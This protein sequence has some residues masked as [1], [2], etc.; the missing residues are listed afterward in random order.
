MGCG[1]GGNTNTTTIPDIVVA[2]REIYTGDCDITLDILKKWQSILK[3]IKQTNTY[4]KI[5]VNEFN[6]NQ[7]LGL[8]QSAINYPDNYCY[9]KNQLDYFKDNLLVKILE[10]VP[11]CIDAA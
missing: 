9:Y 1:C 5:N 2:K 8:V 4:V 6:I 3:C 11:E 10:N 7:L